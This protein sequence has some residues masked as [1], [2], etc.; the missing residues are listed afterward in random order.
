MHLLSLGKC[1]HRVKDGKSLDVRDLDLT[2]QLLNIIRPV[3]HG[4]PR[5]THVN[6]GNNFIAVHQQTE[7]C[8]TKAQCASI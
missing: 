2:L 6:T 8:Q 7:F 5:T 4:K 1:H 3:R